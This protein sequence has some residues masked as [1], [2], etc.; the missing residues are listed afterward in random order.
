VTSRAV[1]PEGPTRG[2][3]RLLA[4][5]VVGPF[6]V[7]KLLSTAGLWIHKIAAAIVVYQL[8]AS[9]TLVG[10]VSV[11]QFAPQLFL[12]PWSGARADRGDRRRQLVVGRLIAAAGSGVLVGWSL[13]EGL[14]GTPGALTVIAA[15][16]VVGVGFAVGGPAMQALV[17]SLV[18]PAE[19][20]AAVALNSM[21]FTLGRAGG[22]A[23]GALLVTAGGP[24]LAFAVAAAGQLVFA[25]ILVLLRIRDEKERVVPKDPRIRAGV[26]HLRTDPAIAAVLV[27]TAAVGIGAD[28]VITLTPSIAEDLGAGAN[29]VGALASAFGVGAAVAFLVLGWLRRRLGLPRLSTFG[30]LMLA[31]GLAC[32]A[33]SPGPV[34]ALAALGIAGAGMTFS[35]TA[36]TTLI[37]ERSPEHLR[38][39]LMALWSVAFLGSRPLAAGVNGAVADATSVTV[40]LAIVVATLLVAAWYARPSRVHPLPLAAEHAT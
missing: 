17:P 27:G 36:L 32:L 39:R 1:L 21:P 13:T 23:L 26:Q 25:V 35:L 18:R 31:T 40:A 38:G 20:P 30:L 16:F 14:V 11:A 28:P 22:P 29:L 10:A 12:T 37:Q 9:A 19:L 3:F 5:P 34:P 7:G 4:D 2:A 8:T 24:E 15:A 6:F 33:V